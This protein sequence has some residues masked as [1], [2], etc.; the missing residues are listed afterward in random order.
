VKQITIIAKLH[1][2]KNFIKYIAIICNN[3]TIL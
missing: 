3:L 1:A 2:Q